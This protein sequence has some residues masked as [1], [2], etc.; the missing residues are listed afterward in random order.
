[1]GINFQESIFWVN[2]NNEADIHKDDET[3]KQRF[4]FLPAKR[5]SLR[6]QKNRIE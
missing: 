6:L 1:M 2:V 4:N 3:I 5:I